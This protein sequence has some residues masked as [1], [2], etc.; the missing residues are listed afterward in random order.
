MCL[1]TNQADKLSPDILDN[2]LDRPPLNKPRLLEK[3]QAVLKEGDVDTLSLT[4]LLIDSGYS[5][6]M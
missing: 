4:V 2:C 5:T 1:A 6:C 3:T